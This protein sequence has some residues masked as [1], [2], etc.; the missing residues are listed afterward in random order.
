MRT[1]M[2]T[3][4]NTKTP[5]AHG[6]RA[7]SNIRASDSFTSLQISRIPLRQI[8]WS[9]TQAHSISRVTFPKAKLRFQN[10]SA[11]PGNYANK[12]I[13]RRYVRHA[14]QHQRLPDLALPQQRSPVQWANKILRVWPLLHQ[15][16]GFSELWNSA[17]YLASKLIFGKIVALGI[18]TAIILGHVVQ[19][20]MNCGITKLVISK[21]CILFHRHPYRILLA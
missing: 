8:H 6:L 7:S 9:K 10:L 14:D 15:I 18:P 2:L 21:K 3:K 19:Y 12:K 11:F 1:L 17:A 13:I 4:R 20:W 16:L 5:T